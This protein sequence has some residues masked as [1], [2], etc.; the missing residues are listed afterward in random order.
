MKT[1]RTVWRLRASFA[2]VTFAAIVSLG[3]CSR[4]RSNIVDE[5]KA[6]GK[7]PADFA[8]DATDYFRSMDMASEAP[9]A[10]GSAPSRLVPLSL[11]P[12][13]IKGRNTWML[14]CGGNEG[15]WDW[16]ANN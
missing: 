5:A 4:S 15:F 2:V 9:D 10:A 3:A 14:W 1:N 13:E 7:T 12:D 11:S 8:P 16:L 6:A